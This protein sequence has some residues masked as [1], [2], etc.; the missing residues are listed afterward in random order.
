MTGVRWGFTFL[1]GSSL[2]SNDEKLDLVA[3]ATLMYLNREERTEVSGDCYEGVLYTNHEWKVVGGFSGQQFDAILETDVD[4][5]KLR[6]RFLD[7][8]QTLSQGLAYSPNSVRDN[9]KK[10][11]NAE[12]SQKLLRLFVANSYIL[13]R[14]MATQE[15]QVQ[16]RAAATFN[17]WFIPVGAVA[18]HICIGSVYAWSTFNRPIQALFPN[19]P[20]WFSPPY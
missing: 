15:V 13:G 4:E 7:S 11:Q 8:E 14:S 17:R 16:P 10:P 12:N 9:K 20:W 5:D 3:K 2:L 6:L 19:Q 18:V 1:M